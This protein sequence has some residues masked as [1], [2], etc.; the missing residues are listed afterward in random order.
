MGNAGVE[1]A[2]NDRP[3]HSEGFVVAEILPQPQRH[4]RKQ[5]PR[6]S[7]AT[8]GHTT[9]VAVGIGSVGRKH[10]L[11]LPVTL[12]ASARGGWSAGLVRS[13]IRMAARKPSTDQTASTT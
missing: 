3:L 9:V 8:V 5:Q 6:T 4:R 12:P 7:T 2:A 1:G 10:G 13:S 11:I